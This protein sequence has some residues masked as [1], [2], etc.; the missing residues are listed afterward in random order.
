VPASRLESSRRERV[1]RRFVRLRS[2]QGALSD[3][4]DDLDENDDKFDAG[5]PDWQT[6]D[7]AEAREKGIMPISFEASRSAARNTKAQ[8]LH[9]CRSSRLAFY[10][11][12]FGGRFSLN[13]AMPSRASADSRACM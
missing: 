1:A 8:R 6:I 4:E 5:D 3:G 12:Q 10:F 7:V 9:R 13:A 11:T 2:R